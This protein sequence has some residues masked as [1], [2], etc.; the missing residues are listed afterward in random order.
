MNKLYSAEEARRHTEMH[1]KAAKEREI[2]SLIERIRTSTESGRSYT[3]TPWTLFQESIDLLRSLDYT[4]VS[5]TDSVDN[6]VKTQ[7]SW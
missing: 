7:I 5:F 4:V 1:L 3:V 2:T 6:R